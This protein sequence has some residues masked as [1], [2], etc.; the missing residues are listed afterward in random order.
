MQTDRGKGEEGFC[1]L[2]L[3]EEEVRA[4]SKESLLLLVQEQ[5]LRSTAPVTPVAVQAK[6]EV[7]GE[8][9]GKESSRR[10]RSAGAAG[11]Y[12]S[13]S[14][15]SHAPEKCRDPQIQGEFLCGKTNIQRRP[16]LNGKY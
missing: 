1:G 6:V 7:Q 11:L 14:S 9:Q 13:P 3:T 8:V 15:S 5:V 10:K 16:S 2:E 12:T 4:L